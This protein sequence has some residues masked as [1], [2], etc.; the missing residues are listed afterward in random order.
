MYLA[1][2]ALPAISHCSA[3]YDQIYETLLPTLKFVHHE[4]CVCLSSFDANFLTV[5]SDLKI[6]ST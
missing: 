1:A 2:S 4:Q 6:L 5:Y 3:I